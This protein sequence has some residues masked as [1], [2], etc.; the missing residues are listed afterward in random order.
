MSLLDIFNIAQ[1]EQRRRLK[2]KHTHTSHVNCLE[3]TV[4]HVEA[5]GM[6]HMLLLNDSDIGQIKQ[7]QH[8]NIIMYCSTFHHVYQVTGP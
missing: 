2:Q 3:E 4:H 8:K 5:H 1:I 7:R 6:W